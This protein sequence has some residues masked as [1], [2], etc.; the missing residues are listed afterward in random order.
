MR[1]D[2]ERHVV[3]G[4]MW[5]FAYRALAP[6]LPTLSTTPAGDYARLDLWLGVAQPLNLLRNYQLQLML[7]VRTPTITVPTGI[8]SNS[9]SIV[10][11]A[12]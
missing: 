12:L 10:N 2:S 3:I 9:G 11:P 8:Y 4:W 6:D 7:E 5:R 1:C